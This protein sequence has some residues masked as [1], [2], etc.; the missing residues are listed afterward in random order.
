MNFQ[1]TEEV[2]VNHWG[3][4]DF[5]SGRSAR[6]NRGW[7]VQEA[8]LVRWDPSYVTVWNAFGAHVSFVPAL[9]ATS[10]FPVQFLAMLA[11]YEYYAPTQMG[12]AP[13]G[14]LMPTTVSV[15]SVFLYIH[16]TES[17]DIHKQHAHMISHCGQNT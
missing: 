4:S 5:S 10:G 16:A 12:Y 15:R 7:G 8:Y 17:K 14:Y 2:V 9:A 11:A 13:A 3:E 6:S 1:G